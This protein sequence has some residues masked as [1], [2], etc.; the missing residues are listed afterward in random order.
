MLPKSLDVGDLRADLGREA[1]LA[2]SLA[3]EAAVADLNNSS[4]TVMKMV[5]NSTIQL[6]RLSILSTTNTVKEKLL[7][8][9]CAL[10][11]AN[12]SQNTAEM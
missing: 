12:T 3:A 5:R 7:L 6:P 4:V 2:N 9:A 10:S 1:S 11:E 8:T